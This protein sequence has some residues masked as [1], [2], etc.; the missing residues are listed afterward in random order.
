MTIC[1]GA[2]C[3]KGA[4]VVVAS[5]RLITSYYPPVEFEHGTPK[6]DQI[7]DSF[8]ALT[9]G[10]ATEHTELFQMARAKVSSKASPQVQDVIKAVKESFVTL[11]MKSAEEK[12]FKPRGLTIDKYYEM[13]RF[14]PIELAVRFDR[15]LESEKLHLDILIA[16]V[17]STGAHVYEI[18][19][20]GVSNCLDSIGYS[21]IG[22]GYLHAA[23]N[24]IFNNYLPIYSLEKCVYVVYE[25]KR[26]SEKSPGV[27]AATD[28]AI[29]T[30]KSVMNVDTKTLG[31]LNQL[32]VA[33]I[34]QRKPILEEADEA[35]KDP[36]KVY[37]DRTNKNRG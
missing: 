15:M 29:V 21:A 7:T 9:A 19:D 16:G 35:L 33:K 2:I 27:G 1:L 30:N 32:Y 5:D 31:V 4:T 24:F 10:S 20:P 3:E 14:L 37:R 8:I 6:I 11:R 23:Q 13:L 34:D 28:M 17:D 18:G 22:S 25:S 12:H 36:L 26:V